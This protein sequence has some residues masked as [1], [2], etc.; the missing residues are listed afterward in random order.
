MTR[1]LRSIQWRH[2]ERHGVSN[3]QSL[4]CLVNS[5]FRRRS[6][7]TKLRVT[8]LS[9]GN[10]PVTGDFPAQRSS[11]AESPFDDVIMWRVYALVRLNPVYDKDTE[12]PKYIWCILFNIIQLYTVHCTTM[13][14]Y[15]Q[16][17]CGVCVC[18]CMCVYICLSQLCLDR[19][20][21]NFDT[22]YAMMQLL[23][24]QCLR[25]LLVIRI[26]VRYSTLHHLIY[27]VVWCEIYTFLRYAINSAQIA[28]TIIWYSVWVIFILPRKKYALQTMHSLFSGATATIFL[29]F[30]CPSIIPLVSRIVRPRPRG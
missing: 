24:L 21:H 19:N 2:N 30:R 4:G 25:L 3:H 22:I 14:L 29:L 20:A 5:L 12:L 16:V 9:A 23:C 1:S 7:K 15:L 6:K 26:Q 27:V 8:G 18:V 10:S 17:W 11:N 28:Y 13:R